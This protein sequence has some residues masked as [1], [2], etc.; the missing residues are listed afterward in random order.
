VTSVPFP[1]PS[2]STHIWPSI[3]FTNLHHG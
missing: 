1:K 2:L 3:K